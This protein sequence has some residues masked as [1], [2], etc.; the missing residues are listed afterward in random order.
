MTIFYVLV[1]KTITQII[2]F[3]NTVDAGN[4]FLYLHVITREIR[5]LI[6][7]LSLK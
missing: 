5:F 1:E 4:L 6:E 3:Q 2:F 7:K